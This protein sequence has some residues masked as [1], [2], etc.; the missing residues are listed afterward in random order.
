M[1][2]LPD[3][4]NR[5]PRGASLFLALQCGFK[6]LF[7]KALVQTGHSSRRTR[8]G[9]CGLH[10]I[11]IR[12]VGIDLEQHIGVLDLVCCCLAFVDHLGELRPLFLRQTYKVLWLFMD[13]RLVGYFAQIR[14]LRKPEGRRITYCFLLIKDCLFCHRSEY[15]GPPSPSISLESIKSRY[16]L[17]IGY[18]LTRPGAAGKLISRL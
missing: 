7:D 12:S 11:P 8:K 6:P 2:F 15:Y 9:F 14:L 16:F 3:I 13:S 5:F 17:F 10:I 1:R 4:R 18:L